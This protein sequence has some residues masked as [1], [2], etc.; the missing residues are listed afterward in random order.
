M[1]RTPS[2]AR[3]AALFV[4]GA[5]LWLP[6]QA[7]AQSS[8]LIHDL[9]GGF[10]LL[11]QE[12]PDIEYRERPGLVIPPSRDLP[13]PEAGAP[14]AANPNWPTD[15]DVMRREKERQA[16]NM[17]AGS[18]TKSRLQIDPRL[19][20]DELRAGRAATPERGYEEV[21]VGNRE[22]PRISPDELR[23]GSAVYKAQKEKQL[24]LTTRPRLSDP[25]VGYLE[26]S[27]NA[28]LAPSG[29]EPTAPG[30]KKSWLSKI[31]PFD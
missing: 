30:Q 10:G 6:T 16:R 19:S 24:D 21:P 1:N 22:D 9:V 3:I 17:P 11:K 2:P 26:P 5:M 27:P 23:R 28:P 13:P 8:G 7:S 12:K 25:P 31:N 14:V 15:P 29:E 20:P 4:G 18:D